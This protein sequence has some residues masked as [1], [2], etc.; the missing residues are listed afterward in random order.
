MTG[1]DNLAQRMSE[2]SGV[3]P[4]D[5]KETWEKV[6]QNK[7]LL[8]K[9]DRHSFDIDLRPERTTANRWK[10]I[11]CEGEVNSEN[12]YW[13]ELGVKH[14]ERILGNHRA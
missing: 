14:I 5:I 4:R 13:Y 8:N 6:K 1:F 12:K 3:P 10:C 7:T 2:I 9:C 11:N